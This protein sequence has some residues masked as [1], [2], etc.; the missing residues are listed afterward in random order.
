MADPHT[1]KLKFERQLMQATGLTRGQIR[2]G[3]E[4]RME[5]DRRERE[6]NL[7]SRPVSETFRPAGTLQELKPAP[8]DTA[9][10]ASGKAGQG[11]ATEDYYVVIN[12]TLYTQAFVVSGGPTEPE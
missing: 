1:E 3:I 5:V 10:R 2:K 8:F 12:G 4:A 11:A 7:E 9:T 6:R